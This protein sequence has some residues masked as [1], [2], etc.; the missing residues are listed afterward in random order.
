MKKKHN[1]LPSN[2]KRVF[3]GK[4]FEVYQW[5]QK[6]FDGSTATFERVRR[7]DTVQ[8]IPVRGK[9][10]LIQQQKQPDWK[11]YIW[12]LAGGRNDQKQSPL[13]AA[14]RELLEETGYASKDWVLWKKVPPSGKVIS[15]IYTFIARHCKCQQKPQ[16]DA[17]EKIRNKLITFEQFLKLADNPRF[18]DRNMIINLLRLRLN[19]QEQKK[20]KELLFK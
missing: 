16:L 18:R 17:G 6:M 10:I 3:K 9:K 8:I 5:R 11:E 15:T 20:F 4:I 7:P 2:A 1:Q 13:Q 12:S 14:K 19:K